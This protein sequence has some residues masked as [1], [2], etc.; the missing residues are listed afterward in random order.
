MNVTGELGDMLTMCNPG[1]ETVVSDGKMCM[2]VRSVG[3][4]YIYLL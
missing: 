3:Y 1:M 2:Q 4:L